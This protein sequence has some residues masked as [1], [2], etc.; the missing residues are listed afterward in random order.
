MLVGLGKEEMAS[1]RDLAGLMPSLV[2]W[3]PA[4]SISVWLNLNFAGLKTPFSEQWVMKST[5]YQKLS[6]MSLS[7]TYQGHHQRI[8]LYLG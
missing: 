7:S 5:V 6:S 4:K 2:T 3:K 1:R 8:G